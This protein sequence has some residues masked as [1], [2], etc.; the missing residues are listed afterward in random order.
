MDISTHEETFT[1]FVR[2]VAW[3]GALILIA[4]VLLAMIGA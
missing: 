2:F 1:G 3:T 4:L